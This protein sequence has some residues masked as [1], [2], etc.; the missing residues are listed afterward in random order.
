[1]AALMLDTHV[2]AWLYAGL[3]EKLP[4][5]AKEHIERE[6]L[7][8]SPMAVLELQ[9][10]HEIGRLAIPGGAVLADL[11]HRIGLRVAETPFH[12]IAS[13]ALDLSWT[14]DPFDRLIA[15]HSLAEN[16]PLL[17]ADASIRQH[18]SSA[19]WG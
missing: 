5:Q 7:L 15:G 1:M 9:Y 19:V 16:L 13:A 2:V 18:L 11:Q 3:L 14:R 12:L 8:V 6:V 4:E 10:L 17:T